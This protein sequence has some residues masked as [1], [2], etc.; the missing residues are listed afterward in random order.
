MGSSEFTGRGLGIV[1]TA[2]I[3]AYRF[4]EFNNTGANLTGAAAAAATD[5]PGGIAPEAIAQGASGSVFVD[6]I[7]FLEVDGSGTAIATNDFI[8]ATTG[9]KGVKATTDGEFYGAIAL[10]PASTDGK[11]IRVRIL[12]C[13]LEAA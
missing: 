11:I 8:K 4:V 9:G 10:E 6:G 5:L 3:S 13:T 12:P 1:A 7:G 2:A